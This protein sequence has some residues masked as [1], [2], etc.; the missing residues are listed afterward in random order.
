[1]STT[2]KPHQGP[3]TLAEHA[4]R[5]Y[6]LE[7]EKGVTFADLLKPEMWSRNTD[8]QLRPGDMVRVR[9]DAEGF[10][11]ELVVKAI[12]P[13]AGVIMKLYDAAIPGSPTWSLVQAAKAEAHAIEQAAKQAEIEAAL[14]GGKP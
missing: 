5:S 8:G 6:F 13:G 2:I 9:S 7:I 12:L 11:V 10:D 4:Y 1:M 3:I 14:A